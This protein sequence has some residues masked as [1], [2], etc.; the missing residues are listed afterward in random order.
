MQLLGHERHRRRPHHVR[1][2]RELLGRGLGLGHEALDRVDRRGE[3]QHAADHG[4]ERMQGEQEPGRDAE[5][6]AAA[7]DRPEQVGFVLGVDAV[8][9]AVRRHDLRGQ[10]AVDREAV[11]ADEVAHAASERDPPDPHRPRVAEPDPQA[12]RVG[13]VRE[14]ERGEAG[15]RP[16]RSSLGVDLDRSQVGEVD[17]D[18]AVG[19]TLA[20][21]AVPAA[22]H[23]ELEPRLARERDHAGDV[24]LVGDPDDH[25]GVQVEPAVE[26]GARLV[27]LGVVGSDHPTADIGSELGDRDA[28]RCVHAVL[29]PGRSLSR[30]RFGAE[31]IG[32]GAPSDGLEH[33][34]LGN[35]VG[36]P[37]FP[38][39]Y[40]CRA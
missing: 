13:G 36:F 9:L 33:R 16:R 14:L 2:R 25:R 35:S 21:H 29:L 20:D 22:A 24:H 27:V 32:P 11:L 1:D 30:P 3:Q 28:G 6:P 39:E 34:S 31:L 18:P 26:D 5:V 19:D 4:V 37:I 10:Q 12:V 7:A 8:E 23:G 17:H 40:A 38:T 15:L